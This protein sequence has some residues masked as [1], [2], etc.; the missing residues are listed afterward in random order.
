M[1]H[2]AHDR[3]GQALAHDRGD[4]ADDR[5]EEQGDERGAQADQQREAASVQDA[6]EDVAADVVGAEEV[7]GGGSQ[8]LV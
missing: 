7:G 3:L 8:P 1:L 5:A 6:G 4:G 2:D